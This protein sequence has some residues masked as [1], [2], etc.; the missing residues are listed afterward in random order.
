VKARFAFRY[1]LIA[2]SHCG[3]FCGGNALRLAA[4]SG[5]ERT[6]N[7][8]KRSKNEAVRAIGPPF[9]YVAISVS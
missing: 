9:P 2:S 7:R 4:I 1:T 3:D 5:E 8:E 6:A